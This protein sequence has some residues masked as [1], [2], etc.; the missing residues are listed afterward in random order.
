MI[1][2]FK[3]LAILGAWACVSVQALAD[4]SLVGTTMN[5]TGVNGV[6]VDGSIYNVTFSDGPYT[7]SY[8]SA[9]P[10]FLGNSIAARDASVALAAALNS[11]LVGVVGLDNIS[12]PVN[13]LPGGGKVPG[14]CMIGTPYGDDS[15]YVQMMD[16]SW[17]DV[18]T[19]GTD[20]WVGNYYTGGTPDSNPLGVFP[21]NADYAAQVDQYAVYTYQGQ[22]PEP[23]SLALLGLGLT[24]LAARRVRRQ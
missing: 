1:Q 22:V 15:N 14:G 12:C 24:L 18:N 9:S 19:V 7:T 17:F 16:T 4:P 8:F 23:A 11:P 5:P 2:I 21:G 6:V 3:V 20:A 13:A 10:T